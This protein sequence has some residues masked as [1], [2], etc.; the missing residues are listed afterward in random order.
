MILG[1]ITREI[2]KLADMPLKRKILLISSPP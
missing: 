1:K 2:P